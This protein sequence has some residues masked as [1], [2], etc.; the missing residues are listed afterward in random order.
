MDRQGV[1]HGA[2]RF[3]ASDGPTPP[4]LLRR[5]SRLSAA[6]VHPGLPEAIQAHDAARSGSPEGYSAGSW[7]PR[8][9]L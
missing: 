6:L 7:R 4:G 9:L 5:R 2:P 1:A 8:H 3:H